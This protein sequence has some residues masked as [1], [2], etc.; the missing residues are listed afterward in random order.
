MIAFDTKTALLQEVESLPSDALQEAL[1]FVEFLKIKRAR[2]G[3]PVLPDKPLHAEL[4]ALDMN[5][6][7]HLEKEFAGYRDL[8]PHE[9]SDCT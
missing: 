6:L 7:I 1:D 5:E 2:G 3:A 4:S 8:Y 9:T